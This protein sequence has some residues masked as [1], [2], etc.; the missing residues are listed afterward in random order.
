MASFDPVMLL[1]VLLLYIWFM[2]GQ[3]RMYAESGAFFMMGDCGRPALGHW[4]VLVGLFS[5][6]LMPWLYTSGMST[7]ALMTCYFL[8]YMV[9]DG[10]P[11][12]VPAMESMGVGVY[13]VA[14]KTK[15]DVK[16]LF[17]AVAIATIVFLVVYP[18]WM[19][20]L[21]HIIIDFP[22]G[23]TNIP[24]VYNGINT[25]SLAGVAWEISYNPQGVM[26]WYNAY[27]MDFF[28][29]VIAGI[30]VGVVLTLM[31][32]RWSWVRISVAGLALGIFFGEQIWAATII[33]LIAK[34][35]TLRVGG[36]KLYEEKGMP[37][38]L[39][40]F[41]GYMAAVFILI[42]C[43]VPVWY[44]TFKFPYNQWLYLKP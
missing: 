37:I 29:K 25:S 24:T 34:F 14:N 7:T 15:T 4:G 5:Y 31:R 3:V 41:F 36:A 42:F 44:M 20:I 10:L 12:L 16:D 21:G 8:G 33:A 39:G 23:L 30:A 18:I 2:M 13:R 6:M 9:L 27:P 40:F 19:T 38:A 35:L 43:M 26:N 11:L 17:K 32:D 1:L 28:G 22:V